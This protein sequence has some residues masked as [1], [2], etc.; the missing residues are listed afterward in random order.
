MPR[1]INL[2]RLGLGAAGLGNLYRA[3]SDEDA[4]AAVRAALSAG[5]TYI[6]TAPYYGHG[7][8]ETRLGAALGAWTGARPI[9]STKVGRVLDPV[10]S[11][12]EGDF[13]FADPLP[14]RPRFDYSERGVRD[15]LEG[16]LQRLGVARVD[17]ALV[18]DIGARV[19]GAAH[20]ARMD[21][22]LNGG[23]KAL[24][25]AR[26]EGLIGAIGI[27]VNEVEA[28][29]EALERMPLDYILLAGRYTLIEQPAL[30]AGLLELCR[31]RGVGVIAGGVF[32]SG[33]LAEYPN[34]TSTYDYA[35]ADTAVLARARAIWSLCQSF[36]VP[37]QAAALQ[38]VLA[39][40]AIVSAVVGARSAAEVAE[41]VRWR[42]ARVPEELWSA[43]RER[44]FID[45]AA[46]TGGVQREV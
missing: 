11:G 10:A 14:F 12:E 29:F 26:A 30:A 16:S 34:K 38:F 23:V 8:S 43:L 41:L 25:Q 20:A 15:S 6:D 17:I 22:L 40:P 1:A 4:A 24:E 33:L 27:G 9:L 44:G 46:P 21:Q 3:V 5:M 37:P 45:A 39:H 36:G 42:A 2:P 35:P 28:C 18:H 7:R 32:N 31:Q 19:H 13:G